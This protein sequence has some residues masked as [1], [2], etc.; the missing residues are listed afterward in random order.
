MTPPARNKENDHKN[1]RLSDQHC[2]VVSVG[3]DGVNTR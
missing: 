3:T 2:P 1:N